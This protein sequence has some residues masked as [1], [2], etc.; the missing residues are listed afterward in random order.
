LVAQLIQLP[1]TDNRQTKQTYKKN[2]KQQTKKNY[3]KTTDRQK[4]HARKIASPFVFALF[5]LLSFF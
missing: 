5:L 1:Q 2:N 3:K 4:K